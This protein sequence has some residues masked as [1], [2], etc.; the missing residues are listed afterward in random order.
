MGDGVSGRMM[1]AVLSVLGA[2]T[3]VVQNEMILR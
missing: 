3:T 1:T 2:V